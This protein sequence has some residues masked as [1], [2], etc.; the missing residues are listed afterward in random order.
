LA[1]QRGAGRFAG[2][3]WLLRSLAGTLAAGFPERAMGAAA[4]VHA[5]AELGGMPLAVPDALA[6]AVRSA[7][8]DVRGERLS[9]P[10][11]VYSGSPAV[12]AGWYDRTSSALEPLITPER[13]PERGRLERGKRYRRHLEDLFRGAL[14]LAPEAHVKQAGGGRGGWGGLTQQP[15]Y[16]RPDL[17]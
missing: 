16:V 7:Q 10:L 14:D 3:A 5:A 12:A 9:M 6:E 13:T 15:I 8:A 2:K 17:S 11:G 1:A 4:A